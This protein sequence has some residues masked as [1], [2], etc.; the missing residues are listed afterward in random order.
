VFDCTEITNE[1]GQSDYGFYWSSTA[2]LGAGGRVDA[3]AYVAFGRSMG[4][5][6]GAWMDVHRAGSQ[7]SDPKLGDPTQFPTGRGPQ[8]DAIHIYDFVRLVRDAP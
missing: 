4:Y 8:G 3:A 5:M 1:A 7:R 2:H 6:N